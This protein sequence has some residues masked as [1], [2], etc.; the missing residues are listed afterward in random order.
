MPTTTHKIVSFI[1]KVKNHVSPGH[2]DILAVPLKHVSSL[3]CDV[4]CY[5]ANRMLESGVY[6]N[7]LK[8]APICPVYKSGGKNDISNYR[9][10]SVL[11]VLSKACEGVI[12]TRLENF[13]Q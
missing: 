6:P 4:L 10:I 2:D 3:I 12:N 8:I 11:P 5:I 7:Q 13:F 1:N 9:P